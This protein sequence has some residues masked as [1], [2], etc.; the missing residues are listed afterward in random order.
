[1]YNDIALLWRNSFSGSNKVGNCTELFRL[2]QPANEKDFCDKY[3]EFAEANKNT[4]P[5]YQRGLS[6]GEFINLVY[7]YKSESDKLITQDFNFETY[8]NDALCHVITE[9]FNGKIQEIMFKQYLEKLG[10]TCSYFEGWIDAK[11]GVDIKVTNSEGKVSAIQIKPIS[12]FNSKRTDVV[13]DRINMCHK[14]ENCLNDLG[15]K[16]YYAIYVKKKNDETVMWQKNGNGYR[17]KIH[18]LCKYDPSDIEGTF[19]DVPFKQN[20]KLLC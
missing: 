10:Y 8:F 19:E 5:I 16:T 20:I 13:K 2:H 18:E 14:Y 3:F 1:M 7:E 11:Y 15:I 12:F 17:F 4:L 9:T 6:F